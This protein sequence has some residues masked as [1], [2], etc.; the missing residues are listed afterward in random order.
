MARPVLIARMKGGGQSW[1][2]GS[3]RRKLKICKF[4]NLQIVKCT[5]FC[6]NIVR[7]LPWYNIR[8]KVDTIESVWFWPLWF[9]GF[10]HFSNVP[11]QNS[12]KTQTLQTKAGWWGSFIPARLS[13]MRHPPLPTTK[14]E[15]NN[16]GI[17]R[18][19][20][21]ALVRLLRKIEDQM[22]TDGNKVWLCTVCIINL[23]I[24]MHCV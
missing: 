21:N 20:N 23:C 2:S 12:L 24:L 22:L 19:Q 11:N 8:I 9:F 5:K 14:I 6:F 10:L 3:R 1:S 4:T 17:Q 13:S 16:V 7:L 18:Y 15:N